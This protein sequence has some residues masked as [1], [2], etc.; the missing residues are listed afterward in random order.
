MLRR[1]LSV[2][3]LACIRAVVGRLL[4]MLLRIIRIVS[5][6]DRR[7]RRG[8]VRCRLRVVRLMVCGTR[9][10]VCCTFCCRWCTVVLLV[11]GILWL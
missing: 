11:V 4:L 7:L 9:L 8:V 3:L 1:W 6:K 5:V 2:E 10:R